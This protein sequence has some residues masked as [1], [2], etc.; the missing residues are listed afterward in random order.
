[1]NTETLIEAIRAAIAEGANDEAR[2]SGA[3]ACRALLAA[4]EAP[5]GGPAAP[6]PPA[7]PAPSIN[8]GA[9]A[10]AIRGVPPDQR[11]ELLIAKLRTHVPADAQSATTVR[12]FN[13]PLVKVPTP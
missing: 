10:S 4:L 13:I 6:I 12:R 7:P 5:L 8:I 2:A 11:A 1:M 9:I 3:H